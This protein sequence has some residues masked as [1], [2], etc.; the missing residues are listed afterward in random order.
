MFL[1]SY[2]TASQAQLK[3]TAYLYDNALAVIALVGCAEP[4]LAGRIGA[5]ILI[6]Q[7]HD[8]FWHDGRLRNAYV[9]G[10]QTARPVKLP[11]WW[12]ATQHKWVED[13]Y[14]VGSDTG[15]LAFSMLALLAC[16]KAGLGPQYLQGAARLGAYL[17]QSF[18]AHT[19]AGFTGGTFGDE[20]QP[21]VNRWKSTEHNADL[22]AAYQRLAAAQSGKSWQLWSGRA[23]RFVQS[24]WLP[25]CGCFA[26]GTGVNGHHLDYLVATDAQIFP[27]LAI[28]GF[29]ERYGPRLTKILGRLHH[30]GGVAYSVA[31]SGI[32]TEGTAQLAL[33]RR[34]QGQSL[35]A[36]KLMDV[37]ARNR[38]PGGSYYATDTGALA[39]GFGLSTDPSKSRVY[40]HLPHLGALAWVALAE[41]GFNPF[42]LEH[43]LPGL[44]SHP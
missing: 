36:R 16:Y 6:A 28:D 37:L 14:Q 31:A 19:P 34:L 40:F 24:M 11:G 3:D 9:A 4:K 1:A 5:A 35:R 39:T 33:Y 12:D 26:A 18:A 30:D 13:G 41:R 15:N 38:A 17:A 25:R 10:D 22:A 8:R 29:A 42:T 27:L 43:D 2:P 32:W 23:R 20:P 44:Q 21:A 7:D